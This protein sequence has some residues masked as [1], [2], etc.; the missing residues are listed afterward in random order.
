MLHTIQEVVRREQGLE[1]LPP[2]KGLW[3]MNSPQYHGLSLADLEDILMD[4]AWRNA[5]FYRDPATR[6]LSGC[7]TKC[8]E[9][10]DDGGHGALVCEQQFGSR[11]VT[12]D[13]AIATMQ[14]GEIFEAHWVPQYKFCGGLGNTL[15]YYNFVR[16]LTP[17]AAESS[18][19]EL[20]Q[21]TGLDTE[22]LDP[23]ISELLV[24]HEEDRRLRRNSANTI[25]PVRN[26]KQL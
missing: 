11:L 15:E 8:E 25:T 22:G 16:E 26:G 3:T 19:F 10:H 6:F 12:F 13:K 23:A 9:G 21:L 4:P 2:S 17:D 18:I 20:L 5:V 24:R 1:P 14:A 7:R